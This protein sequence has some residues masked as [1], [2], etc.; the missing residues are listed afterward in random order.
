MQSKDYFLFFNV[1]RLQYQESTKPITPFI[2]DGIPNFD[3]SIEN[4]NTL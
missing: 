3:Q 1:K 2:N 4:L